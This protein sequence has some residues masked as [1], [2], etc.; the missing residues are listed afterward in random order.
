MK[1]KVIKL[2]CIAV[3]A[4][5]TFVGTKALQSNAYENG[6]LKQNVEALSQV[7]AV[8]IPCASG[9]LS[10]TFNCI[11]GYYNYGVCTMWGFHRI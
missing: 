10:C 11:T 6:L 1:K 9:G 7:E 8:N 2:S 5:A 3:V 4:I